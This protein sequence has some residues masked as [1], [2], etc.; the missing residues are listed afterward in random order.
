VAERIRSFDWSRPSK[1][2]RAPKANYP[3]GEWL[4]GDI[5]KLTQGTDFEPLPM[6]MERNI[7]TYVSNIKGNVRIRHLPEENA[8]VVQRTDIDGPM[9][10]KKADAKLKREQRKQQA[11]A[12]AAATLQAAGIQPQINGHAN[13]TTP[14]KRP[15]KRPASVS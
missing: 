3:W 1:I 12:D 5:W 11:E 15:S 2:T 10:K 4:D 7:R 8:L 13:G 14:S 9:A 6:M